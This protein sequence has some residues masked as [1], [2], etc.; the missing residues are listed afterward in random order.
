MEIGVT[1]IVKDRIKTTQI[2]EIR[3]DDL[4]FCWDTHLAKIRGRNVLFIV[5]ASNRYT[6]A[7]TDIEPRNW[8][9][10]T[11]YIWR[12]IHFAMQKMGYTDNQIDQYFKM[13]G[14]T[15]VTKTH[16]KKSVGRINRMVLEAQYYDKKLE[17]DEKY[18][19]GLSEYLNRDICKP[20]GFEAYGYPFELFKL[21]ME[22]LGIIQQRKPAKVIDFNRYIEKNQDVTD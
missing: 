10:Y 21:D 15:T 7:M 11:L 13:S 1:K 4:V 6:I 20:E 2:E 3:G 14:D 9:Y 16:G 12:V 19:W 17:K 5:N 18:Q 22:R 8:N